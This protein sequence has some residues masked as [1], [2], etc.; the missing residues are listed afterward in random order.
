L[1]LYFDYYGSLRGFRALKRGLTLF[2]L[3]TI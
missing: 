3:L 1:K 2:I